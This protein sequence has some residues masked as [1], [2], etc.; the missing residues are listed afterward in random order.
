MSFETV[1]HRSPVAD[2]SAAEGEAFWYAVRG[3]LAVFAEVNEWIPVVFG[4]IEPIIEDAEF[5]LVARHSLP[6]EPWD[7]GTFGRWTKTKLNGRGGSFFSRYD[8]R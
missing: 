6:P 5:A 8:W 2:L 7:S 3:N 4:T 1:R